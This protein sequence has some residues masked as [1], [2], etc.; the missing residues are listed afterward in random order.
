MRKN[1]GDRVK[2]AA[3]KITAGALV[4]E[5]QPIRE[6]EHVLVCRIHPDEG[7]HVLW[8]PTTRGVRVICG[9]C[10]RTLI[11]LVAQERVH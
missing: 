5:D 1:P 2:I 11:Y 6:E 3:G 4:A 9:E 10:E 7:V 8:D